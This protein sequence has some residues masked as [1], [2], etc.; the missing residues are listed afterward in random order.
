MI[1]F[2]K[3][4]FFSQRFFISL[5]GIAAFF[6]VSAW[7]HFF[8]LPAWL[9]LLMLIFL[10]LTEMLSLYKKKAFYAERIL[11][12]KFSNSDPNPVFVKLT[13]TS[14]FAVDVEI[15]DEIPIQFQKRD[16]YK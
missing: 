6:L 7:F 11:T 5:F 2:I 12:E 8:Y 15:I 9:L 13:N 4:L 14:N 3:S 1:K 10:M 16:F